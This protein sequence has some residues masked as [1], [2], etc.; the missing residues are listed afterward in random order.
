MQYAVKFFMNCLRFGWCH[1][2]Q[3]NHSSANHLV[4]TQSLLQSPSVAVIT[5]LLCRLPSQYKNTFWKHT[6]WVRWSYHISQN[7]C[8]FFFL[9]FT[10]ISKCACVPQSPQS[11]KYLR[12]FALPK[13]YTHRRLHEYKLNFEFISRIFSNRADATRILYPIPL[14]FYHITLPT[15]LPSS[16]TPLTPYSSHPT[17]PLLMKE[18]GLHSSTHHTVIWQL[19][20]DKT[21]GGH[22]FLEL[23][24][25]Q[26][27]TE[28]TPVANAPKA[29]Q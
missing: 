29:C 25:R 7:M 23:L 15:H 17:S 28:S 24:Q 22:T 6:M 8:P 5:V 20:L 11:M 27:S 10:L 12:P 16:V 18:T 4:K 26:E 9:D 3:T 14:F 2:A 19:G 21:L 13:K 1:W